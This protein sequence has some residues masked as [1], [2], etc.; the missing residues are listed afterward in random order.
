MV[1]N[2][3]VFSGGIIIS[4]VLEE[5][6]LKKVIN[7]IIQLVQWVLMCEVILIINVGNRFICLVKLV[8]RI[9]VRI[10][11]SGVKLLKFLIMF[12]K[13][14]CNFFMLSRFLIIICE[15]LVGFC[16]LMLRVERIVVVVISMVMRQINSKNGCGILLLIFFIQLQCFLLG[17]DDGMDDIFMGIFLLLLLCWVGLFLYCWWLLWVVCVVIWL[18][19]VRSSF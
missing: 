17:E 3:S 9:R 2:I 1:R 8:F 7:S 19:L 5:I 4:V 11:F 12:G 18:V 14:Q 16:I 15:L 6:W 13:N 10:V